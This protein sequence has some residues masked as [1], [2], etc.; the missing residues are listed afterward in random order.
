MI[1]DFAQPSIWIFL[2]RVCIVLTTLSPTSW[3]SSELIHPCLVLYPSS[4]CWFLKHL[5]V[6]HLFLCV[7][8]GQPY[9]N[10]RAILCVSLFSSCLKSSVH[11]FCVLAS[12]AGTSLFASAYSFNTVVGIHNVS[13]QSRF[14][15]IKEDTLGTFVAKV[16]STLNFS[17]VQKLQPDVSPKYIR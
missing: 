15:Y 14:T 13:I 2:I 10:C 3:S 7:I 11:C 1:V 17:Q 4:F 12:S 6:W 9:E 8:Y 5:F 16:F